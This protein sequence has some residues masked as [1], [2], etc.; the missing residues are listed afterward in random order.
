VP[1]TLSAKKRLRQ[2]EKRR[3]RNKSIRTAVKT[4]IKKVRAAIEAG[5]VEEAKAQFLKAVKMLDKAVTKGVYHKNTSSRLKSRLA[6]KVN[7]LEKEKASAT[8]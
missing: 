2:N 3:I 4:Q 1:H 6:Q 5:N 7:T 8:E